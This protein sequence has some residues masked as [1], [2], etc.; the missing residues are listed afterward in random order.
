MQILWA[1]V[2]ANALGILLRLAA[3]V[4]WSGMVAKVFGYLLRRATA[5]G[6]YAAVR[7]FAKRVVEQANYVL[8]VTEDGEISPEESAAA[9]ARAKE[10]LSAWSKGAGKD[11]TA[12]LEKAIQDVLKGQA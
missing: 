1:F 11:V 6:H 10:L 3:E 5:N 2:R 12:P 9:V 4:D 8:A 7:L